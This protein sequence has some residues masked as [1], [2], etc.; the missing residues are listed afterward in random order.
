LN[1][2]VVGWDNKT[3]NVAS[4]QTPL[5]STYQVAAPTKRAPTLYVNVRIAE[6]SGLGLASR[7][8][9]G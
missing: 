2:V 1:V 8:V 9:V 6:Y 7:L 3:S 4:T 5:G